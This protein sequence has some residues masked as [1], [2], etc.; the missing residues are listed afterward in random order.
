M[1]GGNLLS[2]RASLPSPFLPCQVTL[3]SAQSGQDGW[4]LQ[5]TTEWTCS[6]EERPVF[7]HFTQCPERLFRRGVISSFVL[8]MVAVE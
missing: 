6:R 2:E 4:T 8:P 1:A 5:Q 7:I 3:A